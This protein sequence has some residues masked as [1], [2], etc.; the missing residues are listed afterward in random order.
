MRECNSGEEWQCENLV[1]GGAAL[2]PDDG[3]DGSFEVKIVGGSS[4]SQ[5]GRK[6]KPYSKIVE[7]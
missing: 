1:V 7:L 3:F 5:S 2:E 6:D 4:N